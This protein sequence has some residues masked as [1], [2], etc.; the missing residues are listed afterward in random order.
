M[1]CVH[2]NIHHIH[3][4]VTHLGP[5]EWNREEEYAGVTCKIEGWVQLEDTIPTEPPLDPV[6]SAAPSALLGVVNGGLGA[7]QTGFHMALW[8]GFNSVLSWLGQ[9][10]LLGDAMFQNV[11]TQ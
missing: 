5:H 9:H 3:V 2:L 10:A 7:V 8:M 1:A 6:L 4:L 11:E